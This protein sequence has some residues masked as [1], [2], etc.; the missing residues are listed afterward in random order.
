M[1]SS[2]KSSKSLLMST[3]QFTVPLVFSRI[4]FGLNQTAAFLAS[5]TFSFLE[6]VLAR[7][8]EKNH[9]IVGNES[10][11][12]VCPS[13]SPSIDFVAATQ[14]IA[15]SRAIVERRKGLCLQRKSKTATKVSVRF[16]GDAIDHFDS[17]NC[18]RF[19]S[20]G[21]AYASLIFA[22]V[23]NCFQVKADLFCC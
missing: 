3:Q 10:L 18:L 23:L 16:P 17:V 9:R 14:I 1:S 21:T 20:A 8:Q 6:T 15:V 13:T 5:R 7:K 2:P 12:A 4:N 19:V 11:T 22:V